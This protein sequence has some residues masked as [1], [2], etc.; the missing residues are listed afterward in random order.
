MIPTPFKVA[1]DGTSSSG[2]GTIAGVISAL[3]GIPHLDT[4]L[5]YRAAALIYLRNSKPNAKELSQ[6]IRIELGD[7]LLLERELRTH[8]VGGLASLV[9]SWP[10]VRQ[11]LFQFQR[12]FISKN[13][14]GAVLDGRDIGTIIMPEA[15][16]KIYVDARIEVRAL[17][18]KHHYATQSEGV[19]YEEVLADLIQRDDR[20]SRRRHSPLV[21]HPDAVVFDNTDELSGEEMASKV[22]DLISNALQ[23]RLTKT[24][25]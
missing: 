6:I 11:A 5:L 24:P 2:K 18:R 13:P 4:G 9:S 22:E 7:E 1:V 3:Y 15:D 12:S 23:E 14:R 19:T 16:V 25:N 21:L 8:L 10:E 17:R 20:D